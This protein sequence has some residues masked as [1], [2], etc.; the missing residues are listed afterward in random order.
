YCKKSNA[1]G[2]CTNKPANEIYYDEENMK[3]RREEIIDDLCTHCFPNTFLR[4]ELEKDI[5]KFLVHL[6]SRNISKEKTD[7]SSQ[8]G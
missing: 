3:Y 1:I 8:C 2:D 4:L 7:V 6:I 5:L